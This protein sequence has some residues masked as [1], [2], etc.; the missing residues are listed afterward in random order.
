VFKTQRD[1]EVEKASI[2]NEEEP[3]VE[4]GYIG[5]LTREKPTRALIKRMAF[6]FTRLQWL[7]ED[8]ARR[9]RL[10]TDESGLPLDGNKTPAK[11]SSEAYVFLLYQNGGGTMSA[12]LT[13][14][15]M[16]AK[17][18]EKLSAAIGQGIND[19][20]TGRTWDINI[21]RGTVR[22]VRVK[23]ALNSPQDKRRAVKSHWPGASPIDEEW[24]EPPGLRRHAFELTFLLAA[25]DLCVVEFEWLC[26]CLGCS[27][28]FV[29]T[30]R[31]QAYCTQGCSEVTRQ[32]RSRQ[33]ARESK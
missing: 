3:A 32:L 7:V 2:I 26:R 14:P 13:G 31:H 5:K 22:R 8:F 12:G 21:P 6:E 24:V 27:E 19:L 1:I 20:L 28:V 23:Q 30:S 17:R 4:T 15:V 18:L 10:I 33:K 16:P 9:N 25:Q 11:L 29:R